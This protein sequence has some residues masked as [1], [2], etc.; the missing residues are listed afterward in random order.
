MGVFSEAAVE[1]S[2]IALQP[3]YRLT[4]G[5]PTEQQTRFPRSLAHF[6]DSPTLFLFHG[7]VPLLKEARKI[8][9]RQ[10]RNFQFF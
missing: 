8:L 7:H 5:G 3:V 4:P 9:G 10:N 1:K 2:I 6:N